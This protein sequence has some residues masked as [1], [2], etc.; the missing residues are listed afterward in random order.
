MEINDVKRHIDRLSKGSS[1]KFL[2]AI[3]G[4]ADSVAMLDIFAD[5][6]YNCI[7]AHCNFNLRGEE[8]DRDENYVRELAKKTSLPIFVKSFN[9]KNYAE[10]HSISIEMAA[11]ELRYDWF[12]NLS[13]EYNCDKIVV[14]HHG[15]DVAETVIINLIRGT[16]IK[17]VAGIPETNGKIIRPFL[18]FDREDILR[19]LEKKGIKYCEDSTNTSTDYVRNNIRHNIIPEMKKINPA[20]IRTFIE[21]T[22]RIRE[23]E[24]LF[25]QKVNEIRNSIICNKK[26]ILYIDINGLKESVAPS[27]ILYDIL[28]EFSFGSKI[29]E[30]IVNSLDGISG[31]QFYSDTH[32]LIKDRKSLII[33]PL[34]DNNAEKYI[35]SENDITIS[36]PVFI[37]I[38]KHDIQSY[39]IPQSKDIACVD[40]DKLLFP[41]TIRRWKNGDIFYPYGMKGKK[42]KVSDFFSDN[43]FSIWEKENTWILESDGKIVWIIGYRIDDRFC[44]TGKS[45]KLIEF[46]LH[47]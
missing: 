42:K 24:A 34:K 20:L 13:E 32:K 8:S 14:A 37:K 38:S 46:Y 16:G 35:V 44:L 43:K 3:S 17:G 47:K 33:Y 15:G 22:E 2:L 19:Y 23:A 5:L 4:G 12:K 25:R 10:I 31:K 45:C 40:A 39:K 21:N 30:D 28:K 7:I 36:K 9:T 26:D 27:T 29:V 6:K 1:S 41:L 18:K 11:R